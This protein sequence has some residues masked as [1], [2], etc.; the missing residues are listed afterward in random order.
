[1]TPRARGCHRR[2]S[3]GNFNT[4][5]PRSGQGGSVLAP[6]QSNFAPVY[7][8]AHGW[9][10]GRRVP[11]AVHV[12]TLLANGVGSE[13]S[14]TRNTSFPKQSLHEPC[15]A[16]SDSHCRSGDDRLQMRFDKPNGAAATEV[17]NAGSLGGSCWRMR[18][19][20]SLHAKIPRMLSVKTEF[21][22]RILGDGSFSAGSFGRTLAK[23]WCLLSLARHLTSCPLL[24]NVCLNKL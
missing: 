21:A 1:M 15:E 16:A 2:A 7:G 13:S 3:I 4:L 23:F 20:G 12:L 6:G 18:K 5:V 22:N 9:S 8:V 17:K 11:G 19:P 24:I 10:R 14:T